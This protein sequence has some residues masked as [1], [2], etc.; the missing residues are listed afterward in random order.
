VF[1]VSSEAIKSV[2]CAWEVDKSFALSKRLLPVIWINAPEV[3]V[4]VKLRKLNYTY[5]S[6]GTSFTKALGELAETLRQAR[7]FQTSGG[8]QSVHLK[9]LQQNR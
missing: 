1:V 7:L 4:P 9:N 8:P 2:R 6:K 5:F 3:D